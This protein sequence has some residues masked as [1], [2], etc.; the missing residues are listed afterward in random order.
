MSKRDEKS[1]MELYSSIYKNVYT[2]LKEQ[3]DIEEDNQET[4]DADL[5]KEVDRRLSR[6][7]IMIRKNKEAQLYY[8]LLIQLKTLLTYD[9]PTMAVDA[10]GNLYINPK[11][12]VE[13]LTPDQVTSILAH[14][15]GHILLRSFPRKKGRDH[16]G[17]NVATDY[18]INKNLLMD[19]FD[20]P[21][22]CLRPKQDANGRWI[23]EKYNN[24]DIT[25][26]SAEK[27][28]SYIEKFKQENKENKEKVEEDEKTSEEF[29][30]PIYDEPDTNEE[31]GENNG[32]ENEQKEGDGKGE[33]GEKEE[34]GDG[35]G[36]GEGKGN[37]EGE[38]EETS[39]GDS[40]GNGEGEGEGEGKGNGKGEGEETDKEGEGKGKGKSKKPRKPRILKTP[41][42]DPRYEKDEQTPGVK[43]ETPEEKE[44]KIKDKIQR[45]YDQTIRDN[46]GSEEAGSGSSSKGTGALFDKKLI[47]TKTN[48]KAI[49]RS[50]IDGAEKTVGTWDAPKRQY[51]TNLGIYSKS[52][53]KVKNTINIAVAIDTSASISTKEIHVFLSEVASLFNMAASKKI[54]IELSVL[55][56]MDSVY[57]AKFYDNKKEKISDLE[58]KLKAIPI[59]NDGGTTISSVRQYIDANK[60]SNKQLANIK[61]IIFLTDGYISDVSNPSIPQLPSSKVLFMITPGGVPDDSQY[62]KTLQRYG[63]VIDFDADAYK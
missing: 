5:F 32:E 47:K 40:E 2:T 51:W 60:N 33:S 23:I 7:R 61:G 49:L 16:R 43:K 24:V 38:G 54:F 27:V 14:E 1:I 34:E 63:K 57:Q 26:W 3:N 20:L 19:G 9:V 13:E 18:I 12:A 59:R 45:A 46:P 50:F 36:E 11:F 17:W 30:T 62:M 44:Q 31:E 28:Y 22:N 4:V 6:A 53:K 37:G 39:E 52:E 25:D 21:Q 10:E 15:V 48:W 58:S 29:D 35:N 56:W 41:D 55:F 8:R 42:N